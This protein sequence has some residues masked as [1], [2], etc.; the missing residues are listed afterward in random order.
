[1]LQVEIESG[2]HLQAGFVDFLRAE[3]LLQFAADFFLKPG[4]YGHFR[5]VD[6][7]AQWGEA[8]L[9]GLLVGDDAVGFHFR[10]D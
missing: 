4:S 9:F 2:F 8:G 6:F 5:L 3:A 10:E 7:E 1:M